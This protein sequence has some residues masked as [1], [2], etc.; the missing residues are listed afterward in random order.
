L[1][2]FDPERGELDA[3][4]VARTVL[5]GGS[6]TS[7]RPAIPL[8]L[9]SLATLPTGCFGSCQGFD[10]Q[11]FYESTDCVPGDSPTEP[12]L[13]IG[14]TEG[15]AFTEMSDGEELLIDYGPQGGQHFYVSARVAGAQPDDLLELSLDG[16]PSAQRVSSVPTC[17]A[18]W[19]ELENMTLEVPT[20]EERGD[21]L[22]VR[23]LRCETTDCDPY[24][25]GSGTPPA[26]LAEV[27]V[28]ISVVQE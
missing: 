21:M 13:V 9:L 12:T 22:R 16:E 8:V 2:T 26:V 6:M 7:T 10:E 27:T 14:T 15:G 1:R 24:G 3:D 23:L 11:R 28:A 18:G 20:D 25:E 4:L 19:A 5:S 17:S